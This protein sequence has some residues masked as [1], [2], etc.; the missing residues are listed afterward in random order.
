MHIPDSEKSLFSSVYEP[1]KFIPLKLKITFS[2]S[3]YSFKQTSNILIWF[4]GQFP[5]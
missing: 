4:I 2:I 3:Q 1:G 5:P